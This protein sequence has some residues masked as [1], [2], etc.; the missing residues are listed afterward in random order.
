M[1][2]SN[3]NVYLAIEDVF[4]RDAIIE[5][6]EGLNVVNRIKPL[7]FI[8][9]LKTFPE[10]AL[11]TLIF[12]SRGAEKNFEIITALKRLK[13]NCFQSML[14]LTKSNPN[15]E[16]D[17]SRNE[18]DF[19]LGGTDF[20]KIEKVFKELINDNL[21][22]VGSNTVPTTTLGSI[23]GSYSNHYEDPLDG[24][25]EKEKNILK[26][27][28]LGF[29]SK[30]IADQLCLGKRTIDNYRYNL[31]AKTSSKNTAGL[32]RFAIT[33]GLYKIP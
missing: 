10:E 3:M 21:L 13:V 24:F 4:I 23:S 2:K 29:T 20:Q 30:E 5:L 26:L 8:K 25:N 31:L 33:S 1:R 6:L 12:D 14:L 18:Y 27:I 9:K 16:R 32:V 22:R 19:V 15:P 11:M 7:Y 28:C 17:Q